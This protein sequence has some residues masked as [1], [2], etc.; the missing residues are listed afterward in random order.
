MGPHQT[1]PT[2]SLSSFPKTRPST[3][4]PMPNR[5]NW[6]TR[7]KGGGGARKKQIPLFKKLLVMLWDPGRFTRLP[8][9]AETI[10]ESCLLVWICTREGTREGSKKQ[11]SSVRLWRICDSPGFP[12]Q[13]GRA[14]WRP[15]LTAAPADPPR[16]TLPTRALQIKAIELHALPHPRR[17]DYGR[18]HP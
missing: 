2:L 1:T 11:S 8:V 15:L 17:A 7:L 14:C 9:T 16:L 6:C 13:Q 4:L 18:R 12:R 3:D 10:A 5:S